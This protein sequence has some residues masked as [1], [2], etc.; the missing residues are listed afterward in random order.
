KRDRF[1]ASHHVAGRAAD[2]GRNRSGWNRRAW[3]HTPAYAISS[4]PSRS[5]FVRV[6]VGNH[7]A[8]DSPGFLHSRFASHAYQPDRGFERLITDECY[9]RYAT[10]APTMVMTV[11]AFRMSCSGTVMMSFEKTVRSASL[12]GSSEPLRFSSNEA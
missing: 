5:A 1:N 7:C 4:L 2:R 10:S 11:S 12:P 6:R 3:L 9:L 8:R